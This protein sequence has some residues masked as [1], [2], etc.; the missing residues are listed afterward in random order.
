MSI[1]RTLLNQIKC[2][3]SNDGHIVIEPVLLKCGAN[4]CQQ[5]VEKSNKTTFKCY[6]CNSMHRMKDLLGSPKNTIVETMV[7]TFLND[8]FQHIEAIY[9]ETW[10]SLKENS[11]IEE[12]NNKIKEIEIDMNTRVDSLVKAIHEYRDECRLE[13]VKFKEDFEK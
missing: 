8:L 11:L 12:I 5:C 6:S 1:P 3:S 7:Q 9:R 13:L 10:N 2:C 4:V